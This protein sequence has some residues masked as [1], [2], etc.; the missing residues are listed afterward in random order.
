MTIGR[1]ALVLLVGIGVATGPAALHAAAQQPAAAAPSPAADEAEHEAL[2]QLKT[3]FERAIHDNDISVLGPYFSSD[4]YGVMLTGRVVKNVEELQRF[5]ADI[6]EL[7]GEGG[8]YSTTLK[9]ERSV[10]LGDV[11]LAR[12]SS[13]DVVVTSEKQEFRFSSFWTAVLHKQ[14]GQWKVVQLQGTID[15]IENPF[16]HEFNRRYL[17]TVIPLSV[18]GGVVLGLAAAWLLRR[19]ARTS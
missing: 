19:R 18:L 5:W 6:H 3:L 13:D 15:P 11:A 1:L 7:I 12:G 10:I 17:R 16:V 8:T 14:A 9:P 4:L 2:R